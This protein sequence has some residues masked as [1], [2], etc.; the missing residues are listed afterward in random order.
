MYTLHE[1]LAREHIGRLHEDARQRAMV[2]Q[3]G[4]VQWWR[5]LARR[6]HAAYRHH[7]KPGRESGLG[8]RGHAVTDPDK[9]AAVSPDA[10]AL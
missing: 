2:K 6:A 3:L 1:A 7:A 10:T 9:A 8:S 5:K 4:A